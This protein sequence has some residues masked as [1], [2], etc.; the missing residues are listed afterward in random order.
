MGLGGGGEREQKQQ[1]KRRATEG[2][3]G[4]RRPL[5]PDQSEVPVMSGFSETL[6]IGKWNECDV[7]KHSETAAVSFQG[8][9]HSQRLK[10]WVGGRSKPGRA[11]PARCKLEY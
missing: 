8:C 2:K 10:Q 9:S 3:Q 6:L 11:C 7:L 1:A 5:R 4:E